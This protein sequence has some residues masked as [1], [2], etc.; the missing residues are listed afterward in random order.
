MSLRDPILVVGGTAEGREI[1][2]HLRDNSYI[3]QVSKAGM[4]ETSKDADVVGGFGGVDGLCKFISAQDIHTV[5]DATHPFATTISKNVAMACQI[6]QTPLIRIDRPAWQASPGDN[7]IMIKSVHEAAD[8]MCHNPPH[9][10]LVT[11]GA[12]HAPYFAY[13]ASHVIFRTVD[14]LPQAGKMINVVGVGPFDLEKERLLFQKY[15]ISALICK[16]SGGPWSAAKLT[17]A[18][19]R[20]IPVVMLERPRQS[21]DYGT[22]TSLARAVGLFGRKI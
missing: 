5:I 19:E 12:R 18:R 17:I 11:L 1:T 8:W 20:K 6:K 13:M 3:V 21:L 9:R 16:N 2:A 7:W 10:V 4:T 22:P 14:P 15:G